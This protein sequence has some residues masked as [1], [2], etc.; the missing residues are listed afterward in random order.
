MVVGATVSLLE[1]HNLPELLERANQFE[2]PAGTSLISVDALMYPVYD[3]GTRGVFLAYA[4]VGRVRDADT[5]LE[6]TTVLAL[7]RTA[8][9]PRIRLGCGGDKFLCAGTPLTQEE[10]EE[11]CAL[12][13]A[14]TGNASARAE[15]M[16]VY[17]QYPHTVGACTF[18]AK[19]RAKREL[20]SHSALLLQ[21][22][23]RQHV[24][25][26]GHLEE[27]LARREVE[28]QAVGS[29]TGNFSP[30]FFAFKAPVLLLGER[31]SGK[32]TLPRNMARQYA[33]RYFEQPGHAEVDA[34]DMLGMLVPHGKGELVWKDGPVAAA[35]R[36]A[37]QGN[38]VVLTFDELLRIDERQL[39]FLLTTLSP[40]EG[41]YRLPTGRIVDVTD[42]VAR[43]E[44]LEC[45]VE[46]LWVVATSNIGADYAVCD[47]D[48]ALAD[49]FVLIEYDADLAKVRAYL[50]KACALRN[51]DQAWVP[52]ML[53]AYEK[54]KLLKRNGAL[55]HSPS[56]RML[57]FAVQLAP[58]AESLKDMLSFLSVQLVARDLEGKPIS[59][60]LND[61]QSVIERCFQL[62]A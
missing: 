45:P 61:A 32:T 17:A 59:D 6:H 40:D 1:L 2:V 34:T 62:P 7:T 4:Q 29:C 53:S 15:M 38:K 12:A 9:G 57:V 16:Q 5:G 18:H 52:P 30:E 8:A 13:V 51:F 42:G 24:D 50:T 11:R 48:P 20:C 26:A 22:L 46:N 14:G 47:M 33:A 58:E 28:L 25:L 10:A 37:A 55:R 56:A 39:S 19:W 35:F 27:E 36:A 49:R 41:R 3:M 54:L 60:Q 21:H 23:A 43:E 31:G 44:V